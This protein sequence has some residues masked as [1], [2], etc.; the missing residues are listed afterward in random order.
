MGAVIS[1]EAE[2]GYYAVWSH[3]GAILGVDARLRPADAGA[4][5]ALAAHI[6]RRQFRPCAEGQHLARELV[7]V[8]DTLF[9]LPGYGLS[10]MRFFLTETPFGGDLTEVLALPPANWTR[11]LV[12][13]RAMQKRLL[14]GWLP[15][16]PGAERRRRALARFF[17]QR[18]ILLQ[19]PDKASPFEVPP[20]LWQ[21]WRL[22]GRLAAT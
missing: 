4:A 21:R 20:E 5:L 1:P 16:V 17:A 7:Q 18:L 9:P 12:R 13:A 22:G 11:H 10:L 19:R 2:R 6:G 14:L 3:V 15:H 8:N